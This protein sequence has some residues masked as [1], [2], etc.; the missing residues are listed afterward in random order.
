MST[1][2]KKSE[3]W[4]VTVRGKGAILENLCW[5]IGPHD[6]RDDYEKEASELA[7]ERLGKSADDSPITK[8]TNGWESQSKRRV[9]SVTFAPTS[10]GKGHAPKED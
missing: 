3:L 9:R 1:Q 6:N 4:W 8:T 7:L 10:N 5:A 2:K